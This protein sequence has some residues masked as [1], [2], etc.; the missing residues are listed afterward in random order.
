MYLKIWGKT[1]KAFLFIPINDEAREIV[2]NANNG[3]LFPNAD[4]EYWRK[5]ILRNLQNNWSC[6]YCRK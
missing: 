6:S 5:G 4:E 3:R 1:T 2:D